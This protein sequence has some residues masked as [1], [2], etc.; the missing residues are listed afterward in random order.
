MAFRPA[1]TDHPLIS[2]VPW[3]DDRGDTV[4][5]H[6]ACL[7]EDGD[8]VYLFGEFKSDEQNVFNGF[9]CYSSEDLVHW[10]FE[11]IALPVQQAGLLGPDRVG[12]RPKVMRSATTGQYVM[13]MHTDDRRYLDA[14]IGV[15]VSDTINGEYRFLGA[16][17][18]HGQPIRRWD[19]GTFQDDDGTGYLLLH[20]GDIYRLSDDYLTAVE[21]VATEVGRGGESPAVAKIDATYYLMLSNKTSWDSNDNFHLSAPSL[22]GP[23]TFQGPFAPGGT[24]TWNS[25][26]S[27][28]FDITTDHGTTAMYLGDRWSFP[29]QKSAAT[30]VWQPLAANDGHLAMPRYAPSWSPRTGEN[31]TLQGVHSS[32]EFVSDVPGETTSFS[33]NGT[34]IA[35][36]GRSKPDGAYARVEVANERGD[37]VSDVFVTFYSKVPHDGYRY[38]SPQL[39]PG[40]Y[41]LRVTVEGVPP[42]WSDKSGAR[43]GSVGSHVDINGF[44]V[45]P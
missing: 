36:F 25:Q 32:A 8:R 35:I 10:R 7:V 17:E 42:V 20:E 5:A 12:E 24:Q 22:H 9:S 37:V 33:F 14:H 27:F 15:A 38:V 41:T 3:F 29:H 6:G 44:T 30:Y 11:R 4:N 34:G 26:C 16:L 39:A 1:P 45:L 40:K 2:G 18:H 31:A 23:W 13:F 28:A 43:F 21:L 19:M